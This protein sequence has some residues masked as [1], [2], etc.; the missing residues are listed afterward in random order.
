[1]S[2]RKT[3]PLGARARSRLA[4]L[5]AFRPPT[6]FAIV[7]SLFGVGFALLTPPLQA[8][9]ENRHLIR[10]YLI[11]EGQ[12][13]AIPYP[14]TTDHGVAAAEV[15]ISI[16]RMPE[17]L[18]PD[19]A[20]HADVRQDLGR[21]AAEWRRPLAPEQREWH[22]MPT[23]Y[24]PLVYAAQAAGVALGR[25]FD[26]PAVAFVYIGRLIN[27]ACYVAGV[28]AALRLLPAHRWTLL[29]VALTPMAIFQAASLSPDATTNALAWVFLAAVVAAAS[30]PAPITGREMGTLLGM[31]GLLGLAKPPIALLAPLVLLIP[32]RRFVAP[33]RWG[34][35]G[36]AAA[37]AAFATSA[38][39]FAA[40]A[41]LPLPTPAVGADE[42]AQLRTIVSEP[43]TFA[44]VLVRSVIATAGVYAATLV[45][46]LGWL[47]TPLPGWVY[48]TWWLAILAVAVV[49]G[50]AASP[51]RSPSRVLC[52]G[53]AVGGAL[54][55]IV[56]IYLTSNP[57][58]HR[59]IIGVQG[60][61]FLPFLPLVLFSLHRSPQPAAAARVLPLLPILCAALLALALGSSVK[62]YYGS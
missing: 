5:R 38:A 16:S 51:I 2:D 43:G 29:A 41:Q 30:R 26:L 53:V 13:L 11:A 50:G 1:V 20:F 52:T 7:A 49:D 10:A 24:S 12:L 35:A 14:G 6:G 23:S 18:G 39:W 42:A 44:A 21:L 40:L 9:D 31:C 56:L 3:E 19:I 59:S 62:L 36:A 25:L 17:R 34:A 28:F 58:G 37:A 47:D 4:I 15:P 55:V 22:H 8:P 46:V 33:W 27:L 60:R 45:G 48:P 57:V 32:A 54:A 61:Y